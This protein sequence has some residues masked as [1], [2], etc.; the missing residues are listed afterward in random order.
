MA[1]VGA[2]SALAMFSEIT[3][4]RP[5][6]TLSPEAAMPIALLKSMGTHLGSV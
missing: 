5:D 4:I 2:E 3:R 6:W 1:L